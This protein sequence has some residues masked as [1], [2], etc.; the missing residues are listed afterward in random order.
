MGRLSFVLHENPFVP[1]NPDVEIAELTEAFGKQIRRAWNAPGEGGFSVN[2]NDPQFAECRQ[3]RYVRAYRDNG[4]TPIHGFFLGPA[5]ITTASVDGKVAEIGTFRGPGTM[6]CLR[7]ASL[8]RLSYLPNGDDL[9]ALPQDDPDG[10]WHWTHRPPGAILTRQ[11]EEAIARSAIDRLGLSAIGPV[12]WYFDR[13]HD[14]NGVEWETDAGDLFKLAVGT[15]LM[16]AIDTFQQI[17]LILDMDPDFGLRGW[18][19]PQGA[20]RSSAVAFAYADNIRGEVTQELE[21]DAAFSTALVQ[22][23]LDD[24][25]EFVYEIVDDADIDVDMEAEYGRVERFVEYHYTPTPGKLRRVGK[26]ELRRAYQQ[27]QNVPNI[28]VIDTAGRTAFADYFPGDIVGT[29]FGATELSAIGLFDREGEE[30]NGE[31]DVTLEFVQGAPLD[32]VATYLMAG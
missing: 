2:L 14:S 13:H 28:P 18:D 7:R 21:P 5:S 24:N 9:G 19:T 4:A 32:E 26:T 10:M 27:L 17:G 15:N 30:A 20:D 23:D 22:G 16:D 29:P 12:F 11:L 6:E 1:N 3:G 25:G 8:H 31:Y